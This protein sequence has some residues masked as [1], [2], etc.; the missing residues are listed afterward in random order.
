MTPPFLVIES[1]TFLSSGQYPSVRFCL[2]FGNCSVKRGQAGISNLASPTGCHC[3]ATRRLGP[4]SG[5][6]LRALRCAIHPHRCPASC[7]GISEKTT[8]SLRPQ[9][10]QPRFAIRSCLGLQLVR[11]SS[12]SC[13]GCLPFLLHRGR[14]LT[15]RVGNLA[16]R[17][18]TENAGRD[19][20]LHSLKLS[21][22]KSK[23]PRF[24]RGSV[25]YKVIELKHL[26][27]NVLCQQGD[28]EFQYGSHLRKIT[29]GNWSEHGANNQSVHGESVTMSLIQTAKLKGSNPKDFLLSLSIN[30]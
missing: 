11:W 17:S 1:S 6:H 16:P 7:S 26:S 30:R 5:D 25:P 2:S 8:T 19:P 28:R 10:A 13:G 20:D 29:F 21:Q 24:S 23:A 22:A 18:L 14:L 12:G 3:L 9:P 15:G 4:D 27:R